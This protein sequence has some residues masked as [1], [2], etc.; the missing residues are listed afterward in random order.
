[1]S[2]G[3]LNGM[4]KQMVG[5]FTGLNPDDLI[6]N[7]KKKPQANQLFGMMRSAGLSEEDVKKMINDEI[8]KRQQQGR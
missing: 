2:F 4:I 7:M 6:A 3:A 5:R 8:T 1:M